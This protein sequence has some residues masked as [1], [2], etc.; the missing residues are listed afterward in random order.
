MF[1]FLLPIYNLVHPFSN[2]FHD[3][4]A[5]FIHITQPCFYFGMDVVLNNVCLNTHLL[6]Q[7]LQSI[8]WQ[9]IGTCGCQIRF[10][11]IFYLVYFLLG[12]FKAGVVL[13]GFLNKLLHWN[14]ILLSKQGKIILQKND[15]LILR[16]Q[17]PNMIAKLL[18]LPN[19]TSLHPNIPISLQN[20][21]LLINFQLID[22]F[23]LMVMINFVF[24]WWLGWHVQLELEIGES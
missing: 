11:V 20:G 5:L 4:F 24:L 23:D 3:L 10:H 6:D 22:F 14:G 19:L 21:R 9:N 18:F 16:N 8:E 1:Q 12:W 15:N 2:P 7:N 13:K 17:I